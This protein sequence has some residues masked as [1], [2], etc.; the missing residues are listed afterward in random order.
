MS[1]PPT[2]PWFAH[3]PGPNLACLH[4]CH[5]LH[6]AHIWYPEYGSQ[7]SRRTIGTYWPDYIASHCTF[8]YV[9]SFTSFATIILSTEKSSNTTFLYLP[10]APANPFVWWR[11]KRMCKHQKGVF[12]PFCSENVQYI[13]TWIY[14][15]WSW[16]FSLQV[17]TMTGKFIE[18]QV[19]FTWHHTARWNGGNSETYKCI[20]RA[21][22]DKMCTHYMFHEKATYQNIHTKYSVK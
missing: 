22:S 4:S 21:W 2:P 17:W 10:H 16:H 15:K 9:H 8:H 11:E 3:S 20:I 6:L 7:C 1:P 5:F 13:T 12:F 18:Q 14:K 19:R